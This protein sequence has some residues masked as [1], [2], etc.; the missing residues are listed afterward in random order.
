[1]DIKTKLKH[2][3][4]KRIDSVKNVFYKMAWV[5]TIKELIEPEQERILISLDARCKNTNEPITNESQAYR[6]EDETFNIYLDEMKKVYTELGFTDKKYHEG[7]CCPLLCAENELRIA[8]YEMIEAFEN[9]TGILFDDIAGKLKYYN[10]YV[11]L[12]LK[13]NSQFI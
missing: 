4:K 13:Y 10:Q 1:M 7:G 2:P 12:L 5:E 11:D 9:V 3:S 8:K 6:V